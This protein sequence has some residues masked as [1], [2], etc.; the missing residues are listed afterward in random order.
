MEINILVV[1]LFL[2]VT[3][4]SIIF[5]ARTEATKKNIS[6]NWQSF[7]FDFEVLWYLTIEASMN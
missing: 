4:T 6:S 1:Y 2:V 7:S 3:V 5:T